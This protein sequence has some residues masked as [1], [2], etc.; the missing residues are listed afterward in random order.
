[1]LDLLDLERIEVLRGPQGTLYGRNATGGAIKYVSKRPETGVNELD[2][3]ATLGNFSRFDAKAVGNF[4]LGAN[5]AIRASVLR[6]TQDGAFTAWSDGDDI[7]EVDA[8]S[9]RVALL[10]DFGNEWTLYAAVD[11]VQDDTDPIPTSLPE[12]FD[13]D[14]DVFTLDPAPGV[15]CTDPAESVWSGCFEN[16]SSEVESFGALLEISGPL[17]DFTFRSL[18]GYREVEDDLDTNFGSFNFQQQ[19]DQDQFSQEFTL[20]SDFDGPFNFVSG[21][22]YFEED[23]NLDYL[24]AIPA[25]LRVKTDAWAVFGEGTFQFT[26]YWELRAGIRYTDESK[27]MLGRSIF[28]TDVLGL[29]G[30]VRDDERSF[31]STDYRLAL[32]YHVNSDVMFYG[33]YTTG[34]KSGGYSPDCFS[35]LPVCMNPVRPESVDTWEI[36][37]RGELFGNRLRLNI[38]YFDNTYEDL[39]LGGSTPQGFIRYNVPEVETDGLEVEWLFQATSN[40]TL[41]GYVAYSDGSY[42]EVDQNTIVAIGGTLPN[43]V[44]GGEVPDEACLLNNFELKNLPEWSYAVAGSYLTTMANGY[45]L[46]TRVSLSYE[47]ETFHLVGNTPEIKREDTTLVDA[48]I[49]LADPGDKW[50]VSLWG[51]NLTD[52]VY[53]PAGTTVGR[54]AI[55]VVGLVFPAMPRTFGA[56]L[57]YTFY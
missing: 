3:Y 39:Q 25:T 19:T 6:R 5:T 36:G 49:T 42:T 9:A 47:D 40:L 51:K 54:D 31:D 17:G 41:D 12:G 20:T 52:E 30:F 48:R 7:G 13:V 53:Y 14:N 11:T 21:L 34:F 45:E 23:A 22:Y 15:D 27:D 43:P 55:G 44:C 1:M 56:D 26:E 16:Y 46:S 18:T 32:Q 29:D 2:L 33:S 8:T 4:A 38:T 24:F 28:F 10:H 35:P 37:T 57:R 50:S